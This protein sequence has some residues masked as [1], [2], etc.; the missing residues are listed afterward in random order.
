M[1]KYTFSNIRPI[2]IPK[3]IA[4]IGAG[5]FAREITCNFK[6]KSYDYF[7]HREFIKKYNLKYI[8]PLEELDIY[9]YSVLIAI[10]DQNIRKKIV[11]E[12][13]KDTEYYTYIDK[14]AYI[15]D[16]PTIYIGKGSIITAGSILTTNIRIGE[17][18]HIN[19]NTTIGHDVIIGNYI[20]TTP[21]VHISGET[22][23]GNNCY[24]GCNSTVRN[25]I[26]ICDNVTIGMNSLVNKDIKEPGIYVGIPI[27]KI[28]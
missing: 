27:Q 16:K 7:I 12:L 21:G 26:N 2:L 6:K 1:I 4:V 22:N 17:F 28:K 3:K 5:G 8:K 18:N 24:F 11:D 23:I 9:K 10:G 14:R 13:P 19:L 25:K 15:L 20:T